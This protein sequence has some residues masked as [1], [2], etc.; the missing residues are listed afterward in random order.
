MCIYNKKVCV[1]IY[2]CVCEGHLDKYIS[3]A[4]WPLQTKI[5][6]SAPS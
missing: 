6:D 1:C 5:S 2:M 3:T 4:T